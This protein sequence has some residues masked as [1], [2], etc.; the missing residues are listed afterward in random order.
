MGICYTLEK[1]RW[2]YEENKEAVRYVLAGCDF[3]VVLDP[4][5]RMSA[6][7]SERSNVSVAAEEAVE[8][9]GWVTSIVVYI[10]G[11]NGII[12][13]WAKNT[14]T[15][16]PAVIRLDVELYS[17][18]TYETTYTQMDLERRASTP[19]LDQGHILEVSAPTNGEQKYWRARVHYS[20]DN[21]DWVSKE[22]DT[23][24]Y[25]PEGEVIW[26]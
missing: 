23:F 16:F 14:F 8:T 19:D 21:G 20:M 15:L 13:A 1:K 2:Y 25:S 6:E 4:M 7:P 11:E 24:L 5:P 12:R 3:C 26:Q 18:D 9:R 22:T 10:E 17:S